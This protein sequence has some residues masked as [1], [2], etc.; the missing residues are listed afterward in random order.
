MHFKSRVAVYSAIG[1][2]QRH[3]HQAQAL[4]LCVGGQ[5]QRISSI[6]VRLVDASAIQA[7]KNDGMCDLYE[8][9]RTHKRNSPQR[10]KYHDVTKVAS[11]NTTMIR[12]YGSDTG[13]TGSYRTIHLNE[14][15]SPWW[16]SNA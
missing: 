10:K 2:L 3:V 5:A 13:Q 7:P 8:L 11:D 15:V 9:A 4:R 14:R 1:R 12:W 6:E 16:Q